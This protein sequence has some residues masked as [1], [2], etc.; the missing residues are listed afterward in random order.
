[1]PITADTPRVRISQIKVDREGR[2]RREIETRSLEASIVRNGL[3][4]PVVVTRDLQLKAGERR[5]TA[6]RNLGFEE[7]P[8]VFL[9]DLDPIEARIIELEENIKRED[10]QWRDQIAGVGEIHSLFQERDPSWTMTETA[11]AVSLSL[12]TVSMYLR[13]QAE[14][15]DPRVQQATTVREAY[16]ILTRRDQRALGDA[17]QE[18]L[19]T[20]D[21]VA[22]LAD[23]QEGIEGDEQQQTGR[24]ADNSPGNLDRPDGVFSRQYSFQDSILIQDFLQWAPQYAGPK[25]NLLHCDFPYGV[26]L[27]GGAQGRGAEP[28]AGYRDTADLYWQLLETLCTCLPKLM[29]VSAHLMFWHSARPEIQHRTLEI[30]K[31][32]APQLQFSRFPLIWFK[33]DNAGISSDS[34]R[35]P[36]H[37]YEACL[38]GSQGARSIVEIRADLYACPTDKKLHPSCK[39]ESMLKHFMTMLVDGNT[40][41]LDPT[42]GSGAALRAAEA[43]GA[44]Q[45]FGLEL[46]P[47]F[48]EAAK[49]ALRQSRQLRAASRTL[50]GPSA[51]QQKEQSHAAGR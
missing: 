31:R 22:P 2:Q 23:P 50:N 11:E 25:F 44:R 4:Q 19:D 12:S 49:Q 3:I 37:V 7:I 48:A 18:L 29:S 47:K 42:C 34:R 6:C 30:F 39:P 36:R 5:L 20:T 41:L 40:S 35:E 13:V 33:S 8:V 51:H 45:V 10:L 21:A 38:L 15:H 9:E 1:M 43:L 27:F 14:A 32:L 16:G 24:G 17:M 26:N 46:D 28:T